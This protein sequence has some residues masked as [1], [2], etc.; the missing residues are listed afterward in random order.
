MIRVCLNNMFYS[1]YN[2]EWALNNPQQHVFWNFFVV[3]NQFS[4]LQ[5][6]Y[7]SDVW[8][9][10]IHAPLWWFDPGL[11]I[12]IFSMPEHLGTCALLTLTSVEELYWF[13]P[14]LQT[15]KSKLYVAILSPDASFEWKYPKDE[16][17]LISPTSISVDPFHF[18]F[19]LRKTTIT[20]Y[21]EAFWD[22]SQCSFTQQLRIFLL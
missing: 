10:F 18:N 3:N 2:E 12:N 8:N 15:S 22:F 16:Q 11:Y 6:Q 9:R 21:T 13:L 14:V 7:S 17:P 4:Y 19:I 1:E 5:D 20:K